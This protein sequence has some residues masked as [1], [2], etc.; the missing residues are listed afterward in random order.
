MTSCDEIG[1]LLGAFEDGELKPHVMRD[2]ALHVASCASC[3]GVSADY[4]VLGYKLRETAVEPALEGFA[5]Q[6]MARV[7]RL[8][9][10]WHVRLARRLTASGAEANAWL[11]M[12]AMAIAMA[13][14]T[15]IIVTPYAQRFAGG[16]AA[17]QLAGNA[18]EPVAQAPANISRQ[19]AAVSAGPSDA[20]PVAAS[21]PD[22]Q[23]EISRLEVDNPAVALWNA[24]EN[25]T[26]V[27]WVPDQP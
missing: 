10:S 27:I 20:A 5:D 11:S 4:A 17:V 2:I 16:V 23:T 19:I 25:D 15:A 24:P 9:P 1:P 13:A 18:R 22:V 21:R 12:G 6:V 3:S 26:T 8:Q 7:A 14:L